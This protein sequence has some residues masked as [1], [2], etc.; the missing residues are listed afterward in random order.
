M[1]ALAHPPT[2]I[3]LG[4]LNKMKLKQIVLN[5]IGIEDIKREIRNDVV[6][7]LTVE[8]KDQVEADIKVLLDYDETKYY[9]RYSGNHHA[10]MLRHIIETAVTKSTATICQETVKA[11]IQGESF[12]DGVVNRI[13]NKQLS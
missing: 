8:I 4:K 2:T 13:K 5:W 7:S 6:K 3:F 1:I 11:H 9:S 10:R 12:I